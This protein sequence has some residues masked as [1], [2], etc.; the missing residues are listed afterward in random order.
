[1]K[2]LNIVL[3]LIL[4]VAAVAGVCLYRNELSR[5]DHERRAAQYAIEKASYDIC[6]EAVGPGVVGCQAPTTKP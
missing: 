2:T 4:T 5:Q 3:L 6:V 1:M